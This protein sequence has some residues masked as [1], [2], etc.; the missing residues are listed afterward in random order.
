M[1]GLPARSVRYD[2]IT[3]I[4]KN[5]PPYPKTSGFASMVLHE[6]IG[7]ITVNTA[8]G[9]SMA[10]AHAFLAGTPNVVVS[11]PSLKAT[12]IIIPIP[13]YCTGGASSESTLTAARPDNSI[14]A[15]RRLPYND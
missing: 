15:Q 12:K 11:I 5:A 2:H 14:K 1:C 10:M 13:T 6:S 7:I 4:R 9:C 8:T 3:A